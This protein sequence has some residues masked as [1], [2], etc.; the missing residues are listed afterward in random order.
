[1]NTFAKCTYFHKC[2]SVRITPVSTSSR[3]HER[4][5]V[6]IQLLKFSLKNNFIKIECLILNLFNTVLY[7]KHT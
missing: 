2:I 6:N 1:M 4:A 7:M 5:I 3:M